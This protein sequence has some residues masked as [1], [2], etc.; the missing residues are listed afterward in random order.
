MSPAGGT[1]SQGTGGRDSG[2]VGALTFWLPAG[3]PTGKPRG[4]SSSMAPKTWEKKQACG[5]SGPE[6]WLPLAGLH[7]R[8]PHRTRRQVTLRP[9]RGRDPRPGWQAGAR[10]RTRRAPS[11]GRLF[12]FP[13][14]KGGVGVGGGPRHEGV[15]A[16]SRDRTHPPSACA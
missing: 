10:G 9:A 13:N 8:L 3:P 6:S 7:R 11:Q 2:P 15:V 5:G 4:L 14:L 16:Q 12:C 1:G